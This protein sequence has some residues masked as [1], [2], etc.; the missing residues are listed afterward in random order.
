MTLMT[1]MIIMITAVLN[2]DDD[3]AE[4]IT[5]CPSQP[6]PLPS[7]KVSPPDVPSKRCHL[8]S[9]TDNI[10]IEES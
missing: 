9:N 4:F 7:R 10:V 2:D 5:T 6:P 3:W 1:M 8:L